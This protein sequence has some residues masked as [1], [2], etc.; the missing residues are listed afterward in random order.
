MSIPDPRELVPTDALAEFGVQ[1]HAVLALA[2]APSDRPV[3]LGSG[4]ELR[5]PHRLG[6]L[7]E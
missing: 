3:N 2:A 6:W 5:S 1:R 4:W 7:G